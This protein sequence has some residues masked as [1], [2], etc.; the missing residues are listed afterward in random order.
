MILVVM[1]ILLKHHY[2]DCMEKVRPGTGREADL[3]HAGGRVPTVGALGD[4]GAVTE[5]PGV[6]AITKRLI[7]N[8]EID[9]LCQPIRAS[10]LEI[11]LHAVFCPYI[12][13]EWNL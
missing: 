2:D 1:E 3:G 9:A 11:T 13:C 7:P 10:S 6:E 5:K 8:P 12:G 4:A